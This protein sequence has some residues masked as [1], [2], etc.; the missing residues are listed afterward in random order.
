MKTRS[1]GWCW[2]VALAFAL[3]GGC[4]SGGGGSAGGD[5]VSGP[6]ADGASGGIDAVTSLPDGGADVG[7]GG[8]LDLDFRVAFTHQGRV[9]EY[10]GQSDL[11]LTGAD[12]TGLR[13]L[14]D[15]V[16]TGDPSLTCHHSCILDD[17]MTWL[18]VAEGPRSAEGFF[19]F[20]MGRFNEAGEVSIMKA[21]PL[22]GVVD[23]HFAG[24]YLY[25][26]KLFRTEGPS[27]QFEIWRVS[28][29][30][31]AERTALFVF[32]PDEVL[33]GSIYRGRFFVNP[34]GSE[35]VLLNPTI[36]SQAV[37]AWRDGHIDQLD[38]ICPMMGSGV[39]V[40]T[41]SEYTDVDPVA[42]SRDGRFVAAFVVAGR[43][44][45]VRLYD[46]EDPG[47]VPYKNLAQVSAD[48]VYKVAICEQKEP[49]QF[50][51]VTGQPH[52]THDG[53]GIYYVGRSDC[54]SEKP[55]TDVLRLDVARILEPRPL[56]E[57]DILNV[58]ATAKT[59]GPEQIV[60]SHL[61]LSPDGTVLV[62]SGTPMYQDNGELLVA[63]SSRHRNDVEV[64]LQGISGGGLTQLTNDKKWLAIG[65]Q[66]LP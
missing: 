53:A 27:Q 28:L 46:L 24:D 18:A 51:Y 66:A 11:W 56:E 3:P 22:T 12:G 1:A 9:A 47:T 19:S 38:Y 20:K 60:V 50:A 4:G 57:G 45:R 63:A 30:N 49:W 52:F 2:F 26:S 43:E 42:I 5:G 36:R 37:F 40:G 29:A 44:L 13:S 14:T 48:A 64:W 25:Y 8:A 32:P 10:L 6:A 21:N 55:E 62:F 23:L 33:T 34:D 35:L 59:G 58:T 61:D 41:G 16:K 15:F 65:P 17:A 7:G 39:C 31:P 54:G